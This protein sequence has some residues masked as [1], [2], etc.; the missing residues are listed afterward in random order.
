MGFAFF[1]KRQA[2]TQKSTDQKQVATINTTKPLPPLPHDFTQGKSVSHP[3]LA[4]A[5]MP[6]M[7]IAS[8]PARPTSPRP[9]EITLNTSKSKHILH[10][11][12]APPTS[13]QPAALARER[14]PKELHANKRTRDHARALRALCASSSQACPPPTR[15]RPSSL[16]STTSTPEM[17]VDMNDVSRA[18]LP[19]AALLAGARA[20]VPTEWSVAE[21]LTVRGRA[22]D[23]VRFRYADGDVEGEARLSAGVEAEDRVWLARM[24]APRG[25]DVEFGVSFAG[26]DD[27]LWS[28]ASTLAKLEGS[29]EELRGED[30]EDEDDED[31]DEAVDKEVGEDMEGALQVAVVGIVKEVV[32]VVSGA[33]ILVDVVQSRSAWR[34]ECS[35][36]A[37]APVPLLPTTPCAAFFF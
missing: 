19:E 1:L 24:S 29:V 35:A 27:S 15:A 13:P 10:P 20:F 31:E 17:L 14:D 12:C 4:Q 23:A 30:M 9:H 21:R 36:S 7:T 18:V 22:R 6:S 25:Y 5:P 32:V 37:A 11:T 3:S 26:S 33:A 2:R 34:S 28:D 8:A 16:A